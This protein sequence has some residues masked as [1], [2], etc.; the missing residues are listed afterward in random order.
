[1]NCLK[2]GK[3]FDENIGNK[4]FSE[5]ANIQFDPHH[6]SLAEDQRYCS[7]W[8]QRDAEDEEW[9][10]LNPEE[11]ERQLGYFGISIGA[12]A[13]SK[14]MKKEKSFDL[15]DSKDTPLSKMERDKAMVKHIKQGNASDPALKR[16]A[17]AIQREYED[18]RKQKAKDRDLKELNQMRKDYGLMKNPELRKHYLQQGSGI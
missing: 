18:K 9:N 4:P 7:K 16:E 14:R 13:T 3:E 17:E 12:V 2:C 11:Q 1:M 5:L 10:R 15:R 6:I 8:C